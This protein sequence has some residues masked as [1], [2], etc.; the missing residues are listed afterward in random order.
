MPARCRVGGVTLS[1]ILLYSRQELN[2]LGEVFYSP[3]LYLLCSFSI[4]T[5]YMALYKEKFHTKR[6]EKWETKYFTGF[7]SGRCDVMRYNQSWLRKFLKMSGKTFLNC[8]WW[9]NTPHRTNV[10]SAFFCTLNNK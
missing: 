5:L 7:I 9:K 6:Y 2:D 3:P 1:P 8:D 4:L 10:K